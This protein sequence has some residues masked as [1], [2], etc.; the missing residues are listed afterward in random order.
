MR[1]RSLKIAEQLS[2]AI[3]DF[4]A[5]LALKPDESATLE[6]RAWAAVERD[7]N[8]AAKLV[9]KLCSANVDNGTADNISGTVAFLKE[10]DDAAKLFYDSAIRLRPDY[11]LARYTSH[12][13]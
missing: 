3:R 11:V 6:M 13:L 9:E 7:F 4:D 12:S 10:D 5:A 8:T 2:A 1:G